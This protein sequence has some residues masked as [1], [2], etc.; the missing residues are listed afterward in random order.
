MFFSF[1]HLA[2]AFALIEVTFLPIVSVVI[3]LQLL[4]AFL[5]IVFTLSPIVSFVI[6]AFLNAF[7]AIETT[8]Y[9]LSLI[10]TVLTVTFLAVLLPVFSSTV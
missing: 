9:S 4:N 7:A 3:L 10:F 2:N 1:L 5:L 8:L 6:L